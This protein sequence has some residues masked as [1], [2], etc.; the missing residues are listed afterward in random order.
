M[1]TYE[2]AAQ[3]E[4]DI[5][6][7]CTLRMLCANLCTRKQALLPQAPCLRAANEHT[8]QCEQRDCYK[9]IAH[10]VHHARIE[11]YWAV[12]TVPSIF[13]LP[14]LP[15]HHGMHSGRMNYIA[16]RYA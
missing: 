7:P 11:L 8:E 16:K 6:M 1:K 2:T 15:L 5:D 13:G 14:W 12:R 9:S 4:Y 10:L 3:I